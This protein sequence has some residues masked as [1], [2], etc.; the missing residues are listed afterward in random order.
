MNNIYK[1][2]IRIQTST[3]SESIDVQRCKIVQ[4]IVLKAH[5]LAVLNAETSCLTCRQL[6]LLAI[7]YDKSDCYY[8]VLTSL[9]SAHISSTS[10]SLVRRISNGR[11]FHKAGA[12]WNK[13]ILMTLSR[14]QLDGYWISKSDKRRHRCMKQRLGELIS[15]AWN[16][17][18]NYAYICAL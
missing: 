15:R 9:L 5:S 7:E 14:K 17:H 11:L 1:F 10:C 3:V 16:T 2:Y 6:C 12:G 13:N 8:R 18:H 4:P